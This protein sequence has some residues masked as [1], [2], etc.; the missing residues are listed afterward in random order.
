MFRVLGR[1]L[2]YGHFGILTHDHSCLNVP[3]HYRRDYSMV[4]SANDTT[5]TRSACNNPEFAGLI[6]SKCSLTNFIMQHRAIFLL[7]RWRPALG[8]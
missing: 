7:Q 6:M 3:T 8:D 2:L 1:S 5:R 4:Y